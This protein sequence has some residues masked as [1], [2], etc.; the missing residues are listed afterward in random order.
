MVID[1]LWFHKKNQSASDDLPLTLEDK[2]NNEGQ[3]NPS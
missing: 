1:L 3:D 2:N